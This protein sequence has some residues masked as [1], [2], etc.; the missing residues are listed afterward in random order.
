MNEMEFTLRPI[1]KVRNSGDGKYYI[2]VEEQYIP[3]LRGLE[4]YSHINVLWWF[5]GAD[6]EASRSALTASPPH[7]GAPKETGVFSTRSPRR[8]NPIGLTASKVLGIDFDKGIVQIAFIDANDGTP[9]LDVKPYV[10]EFDRVE[11]PSAPAWCAGL[12]ESP[13]DADRRN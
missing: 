11:Y 12:P 7:K 1:G 3:A 4:R 8:P 5:S 9:V 10:P 2:E 6:D 13:D